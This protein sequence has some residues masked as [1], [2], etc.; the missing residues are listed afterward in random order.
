[1]N[2]FMLPDGDA[3]TKG[4][5]LSVLTDVIRRYRE[6]A[7]RYVSADSNVREAENAEQHR[8]ISQLGALSGSPPTPTNQANSMLQRLGSMMGLHS[9]RVPSPAT[10]T[11]ALPQQ[12][13][14]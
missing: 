2:H 5:K 9:L 13:G 4:T 7:L 10:P 3:A 6:G 8:V 12:G 11:T 1:M 14:Q